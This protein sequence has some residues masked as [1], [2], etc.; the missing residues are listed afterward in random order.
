MIGL[1]FNILKNLC[2]LALAAGAVLPFVGYKLIFD[3]DAKL[4]SLS[5]VVVLLL[6]VLEYTFS[7]PKVNT[8]KYTYVNDSMLVRKFVVI[9]FLVVAALI[10]YFSSEFFAMLV[11]CIS[12]IVAAELAIVVIKLIGKDFFISVDNEFITVNSTK[13]TRIYSTSIKEIEYRYESF[14]IQL[15]NGKVNLIDTKK[16]AETD[17]TSFIEEMKQFITRNNVM[18][19]EESRLNLK[20]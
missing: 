9:L 17:I 10:F 1:L 4:I 12:C 15:K 7:K 5:I 13:N 11:L 18:V 19:N 14:Y 20:F 8:K 16:I 6:S 2:L 3:I